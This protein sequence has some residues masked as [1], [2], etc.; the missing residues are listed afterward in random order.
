MRWVFAAVAILFL[1]A[2]SEPVR[3]MA[4]WAISSKED[5]K[6]VL[7]AVILQLDEN[8]AVV[9]LKDQ[10]VGLRTDGGDMKVGILDSMAIDDL[11]RLGA[12]APLK[13]RVIVT[14]GTGDP[15]T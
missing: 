2:A 15:Q 3:P 13:R 10:T 12:T 6:E 9:G 4:A 11:F 8:R 5:G 7:R 14:C 1:S